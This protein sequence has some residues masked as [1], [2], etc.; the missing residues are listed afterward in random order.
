MAWPAGDAV[1]LIRAQRA[2]ACDN[3]VWSA[4]FTLPS[5]FVR[6]AREEQLQWCDDIAWGLD[7]GLLLA[8]LLLPSLLLPALLLP[9]L[10]PSLLIEPS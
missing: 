7:R 8:S 4:G 2:M 5:S 3:K 1:L 9:S 6:I 10:L